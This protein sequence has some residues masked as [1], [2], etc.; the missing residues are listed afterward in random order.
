M[1]GGDILFRGRGADVGAR[2]P[3][4]LVRACGGALALALVLSIDALGLWKILGVPTWVLQTG[5]VVA[6]AVIAPTAWGVLLWL[7]TGA[8]ATVIMLVMYTPVVQPMVG[9]FVRVDVDALEPVDAIVVLSGGLMDDGRINGQAL[10]RLLSGIALAKR[11]GI[12]ELALSVV[13]YADRRPAVSSEADQ[14][15]LVQ[16]MAPEFTPRLVRDVHS[17]RDEAMAFAAMS[18]THG[19]QRVAVVTSPMHSRRACLAMEKAGLSVECRPAAGRDYSITVMN[20]GENRRL[21]FQD[22]LYECAGIVLYRL[23]DWI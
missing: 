9:A 16:L 22:I 18:R 12:P 11:H 7:L 4:W 5:A 23:R 6:G 8:T 17:T 19:W 21:A 2:A 3:D 13:S 10:D 20:R 15:A 1:I 14:I